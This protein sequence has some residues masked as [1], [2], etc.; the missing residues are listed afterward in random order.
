MRGD[1]IPY[2]MTARADYQG[3]IQ[4]GTVCQQGKILQVP[5]RYLDKRDS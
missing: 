3:D 2:P 5:R 1:Y 4:A